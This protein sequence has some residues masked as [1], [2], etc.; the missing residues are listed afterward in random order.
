MGAYEFPYLNLGFFQ[1]TIDIVLGE[2]RNGSYG[3]KVELGRYTVFNRQIPHF[4][5][6]R[7]APNQK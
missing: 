7:G 3:V 2:N 6:K 5:L 1:S 4:F